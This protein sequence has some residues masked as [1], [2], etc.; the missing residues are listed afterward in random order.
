MSV[1]LYVIKGLTR[2]TLVATPNGLNTSETLWH[3][4]SGDWGITRA[5][6]KKRE[7]WDSQRGSI[8]YI[9]SYARRHGGPGQAVL[10][11]AGILQ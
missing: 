4:S 1:D 7:G 9:H 6:R 3:R 11:A 10:C 8:Q 5:G 2:L